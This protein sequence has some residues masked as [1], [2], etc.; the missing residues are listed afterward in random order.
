MMELL[1]GPM[2]GPLV[3]G[4][5]KTTVIM[6]V[7]MLSG[8]VL[9]W[10]ERKQSAIMQDRIGANRAAIVIPGLGW[11]FPLMGLVHNLADAAKGIL[12]EDFIPPFAN[13]YLHTLAPFLAC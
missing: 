8:L 7:V 1:N 3:F 10:V 6:S 12:K 13:P 4:L 2:L 9:S 5:L 11:R